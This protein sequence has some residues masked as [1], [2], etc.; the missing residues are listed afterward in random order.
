MN[1]QHIEGPQIFD[2]DPL[3]LD[4]P[5]LCLKCLP[6]PPTLH[7]STPFATN[8]SWS[9]TP[10]TET[11]FSALNR[12]FSHAIST[13]RISCATAT[14][15]PRDD[16]SYPPKNSLFGF[17]DPVT[18]AQEASAAATALETKLS[19]HLRAVFS[20]WTALNLQ[21]RAEIWSL[22]VARNVGTK[23]DEIQKLRKDKEFLLQENTHLKQQIDEL[24]RL[25]R[26]R[27]FTISAPATVRMESEIMNHFLSIAADNTGIGYSTLDRSMHLDTVVE[28]AI[29]RWKGVVKETRT[30]GVTGQRSFSGDSTQGTHLAPNLNPQNTSSSSNSNGAG[31][32]Q[33]NLQPSPMGK[34]NLNVH[35]NSN[36]N[37]HANSNGNGTSNGRSTRANPTPSITMTNEEDA[38][39]SDHDI[40]ADA[41]VDAEGD[42]D[43][44]LD[45]DAD[46]DADADMEEVD[47][48]F[49]MADAP[50]MASKRYRING[51]GKENE[52][53]VGGYHM[54]VGA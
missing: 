26:P 50:P 28:R 4:F 30:P 29:S 51:N 33:P 36:S 2:Y 43:P 10:P 25:Q 39:G 49:E 15:V 7:Q 17:D 9:I 21:R 40:D 20:H 37:S 13:F 35:D 22:E 41:D 27:E 47:G 8:D 32:L 52:Q 42:V 14:T 3:T 19:E 54:R 24:S 46:A 18:V 53:V 16:L 48:N 6:P 11:Q 45:A 44:D 34:R 31:S 1:R 12:H 5:A 23:S 38:M